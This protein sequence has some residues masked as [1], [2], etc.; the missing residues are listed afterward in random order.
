M[1]QDQEKRFY[2]P[3]IQSDLSLKFFYYQANMPTVLNQYQILEPDPKFSIEIPP[4]ELDLILIPMLGFDQ[5]GHRLGMG[6]GFYDRSLNHPGSYL[7]I[8]LAFNILEQINLPF[9]PHDVAMDLILTE[10]KIFRF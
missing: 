1:L 8:G 7:K 9:E 2:L 6:K 3:T 5:K 4:Q 10:N